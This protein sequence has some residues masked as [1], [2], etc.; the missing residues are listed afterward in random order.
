MFATRR[1]WGLYL[2]LVEERMEN[3]EKRHGKKADEAARERKLDVLEAA[4]LRAYDAE[5]EQRLR[6]WG[7]D[8]PIPEQ[9]HVN[10]ERGRY[11]V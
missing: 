11:E 4:H 8:G 1:H 10:D 3:W 6:G 2:E 7:F 5:L 9:T